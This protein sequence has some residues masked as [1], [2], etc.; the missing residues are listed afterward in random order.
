MRVSKKDTFETIKGK[1]DLCEVKVAASL[2]KCQ[3]AEAN[4]N[5]ARAARD[6]TQKAFEN[7]IVEQLEK[8]WQKFFEGHCLSVE[9]IASSN[10][11]F[12]FCTKQATS[13]IMLKF[14]GCTFL[15]LDTDLDLFTL[16]A[17]EDKTYP[18]C[19]VAKK[20]TVGEKVLHEI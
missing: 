11:I 6:R 10:C 4:F 16:E 9:R 20:R 12:V 1:L 13:R 14:D 8:I 19:I 2:K 5:L 17:L 18:L 15:D 3:E 7:H